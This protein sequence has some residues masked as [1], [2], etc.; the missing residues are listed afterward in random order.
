MADRMPR[1]DVRNDGIGPYAVFY[2]DIDN[3]EYRSSP[4][5]KGTIANDIGRNALGGFLRRNIPIV[6]SAAADAMTG[7]DPRYTYSLTPEQLQSAWNQVKENFHECPTC[8]RFACNSDW[9]MQAGFCIEDS[10]RK[11]QLAQAQGEQAAGVIKGF[12]EVFGLGDA[13]RKASEAANQ[14]AA[15]SARCPNDN[16]LA[17]AGIKFCPNCGTA[18]IQPLATSAKCPQCG[19]ETHGA[20]FCPNCGMKQPEPAAAAP[21]PAVC[22]HCGAQTKGAKFCPECGTKLV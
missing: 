7:Q 16:T 22:P 11:A 17:P 5:V 8:K 18:M 4:D 6:G 21:A 9:D 10:P 2:C 1:Y 13:V 14:A 19:T 3:R 15:N 20:K 12:A